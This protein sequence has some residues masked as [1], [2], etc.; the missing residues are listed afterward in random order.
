MLARQRNPQMKDASYF[1]KISPTISIQ[2]LNMQDVPIDAE[3]DFQ[4]FRTKMIFWCWHADATA[5][6]CITGRLDGKPIVQ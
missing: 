4:L 1:I 5:A 3:V 6:F 2:V